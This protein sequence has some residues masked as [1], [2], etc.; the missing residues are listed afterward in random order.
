MQEKD[1]EAAIR[2]LKAFERHDHKIKNCSAAI[3]LSFLYFHERDYRQAAKFVDVAIEADR[4]E[5]GKW[6]RSGWEVAGKRLGSGWEA[7]KWPEQNY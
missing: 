7:G 2:T 4:F 5:A 1:T 3:N 6:L